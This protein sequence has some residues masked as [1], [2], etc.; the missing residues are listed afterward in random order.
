MTAYQKSIEIV[1]TMKIEEYLPFSSFNTEDIINYIGDIIPE[2][3]VVYRNLPAFG[4]GE[5]I[6]L[7]VQKEAK[8]YESRGLS[9]YMFSDELGAI[10]FVAMKEE[11]ELLLEALHK[12]IGFDIDYFMKFNAID[13]IQ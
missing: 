13:M 11:Y 12:I 1:F 4:S 5:K 3:I 6:T 8:G 9:L 7:E 2:S 10:H